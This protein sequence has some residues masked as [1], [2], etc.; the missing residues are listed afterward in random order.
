MHTCSSRNKDTL[1]CFFKAC[2]TDFL[3][4][5]TMPLCA[6]A[7]KQSLIDEERR[8]LL[9]EAA[10]LRDYLPRGIIR[11]QADLAYINDIAAQMQGTGLRR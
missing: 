2:L 11:D 10:E 1:N 9:R 5:L 7:R 4:T 8:K 3:L 6:Q